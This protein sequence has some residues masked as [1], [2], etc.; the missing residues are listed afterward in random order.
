MQASVATYDRLISLHGPDPAWILEASRVN[1]TMGD[2]V[3]EDIGLAD[4]AGAIV[5]YRRSTELDRNALQL[6][7]RSARAQRALT[8]MQF[9]IGNA[10][11]DTD[12][13]HALTDLR[14]SLQSYDAFPA[15]ER[16]KLSN[17]R[18]RALIVRK[19]AV[20]L[21]ELGEFSQADPLFEDALKTFQ[22]IEAA[23]TAAVKDVRALGDL[24]RMQADMALNYE[25]AADPAL[26]EVP[27]DRR[28]NLLIARQIAEQDGATIQQIMKQDT[29]HP[30]WKA[31]LASVQ[32]QIAAIRS[33]LHD[34]A[35][36]DALSKAPLAVLK[37]FANKENASVR[38]I[39]L[40]IAALLRGQP[41][42]LR[43]REFAL[44]C[45]EREVALTHRKDTES[46]L[47]LAQVY[48]GTGQIDKSRATAN[49]G[50]ALLPPT[51]P[52]SPK[53]NMRKLLEIQAQPAR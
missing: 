48:R 5:A 39:G 24:K 37:A 20:A 11:L 3:G 34:P 23:D 33:A 49:D 25:N 38:L 40:Y 2:V 36:T 29:S 51:P 12:P 4:V 16:S 30:D 19:Q 22:R 32:V 14:I 8:N 44:A 10:E 47:W 46:L 43:D 42:L 50:L 52:G 27:G 31:E 45:A 17:V 6:D 41:A 28:R 7:P 18:L 15:D 26:A 53:P 1:E 9:K 35:D 13:A 21:S